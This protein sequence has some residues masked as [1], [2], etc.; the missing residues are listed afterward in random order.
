MVQFNKNDE[1]VINAIMCMNI[2]DT[3]LD[4]KYSILH[5]SNYMKYPKKAD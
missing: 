1:I 2:T 4:A 3:M 5:D